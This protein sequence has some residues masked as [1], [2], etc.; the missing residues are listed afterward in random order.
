M[1]R[2]EK[3][4]DDFPGIN[5]EGLFLGSVFHSVDHAQFVHV[6]EARDLTPVDAGRSNHE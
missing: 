6:L 5:A 4:A 2:F 1:T 3:Y